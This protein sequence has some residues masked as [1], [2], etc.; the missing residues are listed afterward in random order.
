MGKCR[1]NQKWFEHQDAAGHLISLWARAIDDENVLC[2][3]CDK[4]VLLQRG[5]Q[6]IL[7]HSRGEKYKEQFKI[8]FEPKQLHLEARRQVQFASLAKQGGAVN[9]SLQ[10]FSPRENAARAELVWTLRAVAHNYSFLSCEGIADTFRNMFPDSKCLAEFGL[11]PTKMRYLI[12]EA[13]GPFFVEKLTEDVEGGVLNFYFILLD[14]M[15][16]LLIF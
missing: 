15:Y 16:I 13:L 11:S 8:K 7:Q 9:Q 1:F 4:K 5:L 6:S 3:A 2:N 12:T 10:L 14:M